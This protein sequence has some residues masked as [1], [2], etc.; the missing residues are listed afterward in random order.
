MRGSRADPPGPHPTPAPRPGGRILWGIGLSATREQGAHLLDSGPLL[1]KY[2]RS[3]MNIPHSV[4]LSK[5]CP[6]STSVPFLALAL[7]AVSLAGPAGAALADAPVA[8]TVPVVDEYF[9]TKVT[10]PYRWMEESKDPEFQAYLKAEDDRTRAALKAIPGREALITRIEALEETIISSSNVVRRHGQLFYEKISPGTNLPKLY[11][12]NGA[13]ERVLLDP[14]AFSEGTHHQA[15]SY[16]S[17]S[18]DGSHVAV[19]LSGGGS[20]NAI[21]HFLETATGKQLAETIDRSQ[22]GAT[23]WRGDGKAIY[24]LRLQLLG[25]DAPR[26]AKFQNI[27]TYVHVLGTDPATDVAVFGI[28]TSA[29]VA[30]TP[31]DFATAFVTPGS[32]FAVGLVIHGVQNEIDIYSAPKADLDGGKA[33][34]T[35]V[36][37]T[38]AGVTNLTLHGS[39]LYLMTHN[40]ALRFKVVVTDAGHPD[41]A[42]ARLIVP[43]S[44]RVLED[45]NAAHDAVYVRSLEDGLGR[46]TRIDWDGK[47]TEVALPINGTVDS[48]TTEFD[49]DGFIAQIQGWT[50]SPL[51]Y[52]YDPA[53]AVLSDTRLDPPS[54]VDY[55]SVTSEEVKVRAADGTMIPLS[56]IHRKDMKKDGSSPVLLY[57]YGSYGINSNPSYSAIR[58][59][60][61]ERGGAYAIAHVRGGGEYGEEWHLAGKDANQVKTV[62]DFIDCGKW[63]VANGYTSAARLGARGGSAGGITMGGAITR[64]PDLFAAILDE[65][66]VSDQLRIETTPNGPPNIPEFGSVKTADGFKNLYATSAVHHVKPG[67]KYPAV[68]LTT[69]ANDPRVDPWQAAK[70]AATLQAD[71]AGTAPILLRVDY[72]GGHGLIGATKSQAAVLA[73]DEYSFLLWNMGVEGFQPAP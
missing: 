36:C 70:M 51:W 20:E 28:G 13:D 38:S 54:S 34:W 47:R 37:D 41:V 45:I 29:G 69:G 23:S 27:R 73:A 56:I 12:R 21:M 24:Y 58:M 18:N 25:A 68:M 26:T 17:V 3:I 44:D 48:L 11:V 55:S 72:E 43:P 61:F 57:A 5:R 35:K 31:D 33:A 64:A 40:D 60:W 7:L 9:G 6:G 66:P 16:V 1:G 46:V 42:H 2:P 53:T 19:G 50:V 49:G 39:Q 14:Q 52:S 63:L 67:V 22:F 71:T 32:D 8:K 4:R 10:D 62:T 15:I 65:I 30:I 59:A